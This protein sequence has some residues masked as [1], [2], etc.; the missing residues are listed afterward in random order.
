MDRRHFLATSIAGLAAQAYAQ[1]KVRRVGLIGC[2]WYG[3]IDLLR[4]IQI[5][6]VEVVSLCDVD[7][8]MLAQ[9]AE[10]VAGRQKSHK[11]PRMYADYREMLRQKDLD[12][13]LIATPDHW[14]ALTM[15]EAVKSGLDVYVQKPIS[16]DIEEGRAMLAAA[17]KYK[18]VVQVGM[19]RRSTPH[20]AEARD[21]IV[22]PGK[23]GKVGL[24]EICCYYHMRAT[25]N[26]PDTR[27]PANLDYEM[28]TG[29]A[30]MR[31]YNSLVHPRTWRA[32]ME[33]G[34]GIVGDMCVHMFDMTR[35]MLNLG[36][37]K[38]I[39]STG[40]ILID[41]SSK[42][43]ISD[44]QTVTFHY[45]D[46]DVVWQHRSW[47]DAPDPKYPWAAMFYGDKGTLKAGVFGYDFKPEKGDAIH[48]DVTYEYEQFPEDK[49]EKDL[50]RHVAPAIRR[51]MRDFL[52]NIDSRGKPVS[53]I[54]QGY[55][56]AS[57][58]ILGNLSMKLG[59]T[60]AWD[61]RTERVVNDA[62]A[63]R[64][65]ARPYRAPWTHPGLPRP[66]A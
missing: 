38:S 13:V 25:A 10:I 1:E 20:L 62:E 55:I 51:H 43:N 28:W 24:V 60:L 47:G 49:T 46:L 34:N 54:E 3:K 15:I 9:A 23:L 57:S 48:R 5:S 61:A 58:C 35:W 27:P 64:L 21:E 6:P 22:V 45:D 44:T 12:L 32:F 50:E 26:P 52:A 29:P 11:T 66:T 56:S 63:N 7:K 41:K 37:P 39:S 53:D 40:G 2:G 17:R 4:L 8:D 18:R 30:P 36:W 42:A 16:V 31:P 14:H 19:Q 59:R 65:L 33:Y